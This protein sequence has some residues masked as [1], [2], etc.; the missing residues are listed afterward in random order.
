VHLPGLHAGSVMAVINSPALQAL[1]DQV[2]VPPQAAVV[3]AP[4]APT[5]RRN[6]NWRLALREAGGKSAGVVLSPEAVAALEAL[7]DDSLLGKMNQSAVINTAILR[8][9]GTPPRGYVQ[10]DA[11]TEV[12]VAAIRTEWGIDNDAEAVSVGLR[13]F[14]KLQRNL[15]RLEL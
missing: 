15:T 1:Q 4:V 7:S 9:L 12:A 11:D 8:L 5:T 14:A 13:A 6:R 3:E 2:D 10:L